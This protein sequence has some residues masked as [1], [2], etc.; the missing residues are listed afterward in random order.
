MWLMGIRL[1]TSKRAVSALNL[2]AIPPARV[3]FFYVAFVYLFE[4]VLLFLFKTHD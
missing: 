2:R 1:S 4:V 3:V